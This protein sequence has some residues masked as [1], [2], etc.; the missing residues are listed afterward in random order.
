MNRYTLAALVF[1]F[2]AFFAGQQ[3]AYPKVKLGAGGG[4]N[5]LQL[6]LR[7]DRREV[8]IENGKI[9]TRAKLKLMLVNVGDKAIKLNT[10]D[11]YWSRIRSEVKATPADSMSTTQIAADRKLV[12]P[13]AA[14]FPEI[15]PGET[16]TF[17]RDLTFPG[18]LPQGGS[19]LMEYDVSKPG[20][21]RIRVKYM[22]SAID[23]PAAQ[24][25]WT[26]EIDSNEIVITAN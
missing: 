7:A 17:T 21:F 14:D 20:E 11:F 22:S 9:A 10:Y 2:G 8:E 25:A 3:I 24:G 26:G 15:K 12:E 16:W 1:S 5:G 6:T 13:Q 23:V 18:A 19:R 4:V